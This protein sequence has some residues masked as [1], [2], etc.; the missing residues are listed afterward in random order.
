MQGMLKKN[1]WLI[2]KEPNQGADIRLFCFPYLGGGASVY[3]DWP[4]LLPGH[5][6]VYAVQLPGREERA[7]E[8]PMYDLRALIRQL[9]KTMYPFMDK[10]YAM[11][12]H[13]IGAGIAMMVADLIFR[14][15]DT[16][17][18]R[19]FIGAFPSVRAFP[20]IIHRMFG[21]AISEKFSHQWVIRLLS[22]LDVPESLLSDKDWLKE[23]TPVIKADACL[24]NAFLSELPKDSG[25]ALRTPYKMTVFG[26]DKDT[27][28]PKEHLLPWEQWRGGASK[29]KVNFL[30]GGH[31]FLSESKARAELIRAIS[32]LLPKPCQ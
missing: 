11:Y 1:P 24:V 22:L 4:G 6:E 15:C 23:I 18:E 28:Y 7:G 32:K 21:G 16:V 2:N 26:G 25:E 12:G 20:E 10:P 5:I 31:L 8:R 3:K 29:V 9:A 27:I 19:V 17:P 30:N 13:S 14:A